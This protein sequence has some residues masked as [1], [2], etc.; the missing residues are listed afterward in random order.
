MVTGYNY[1]VTWLQRNCNRGATALQLVLF[2][3][4]IQSASQTGIYI[5]Y[6]MVAYYLIAM[7]IQHRYTLNRLKRN[8]VLTWCNRIVV[9]ECFDIAIK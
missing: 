8:G 3:T 5:I 4:D 9:A 2:Y 7:H 1:F 6:N